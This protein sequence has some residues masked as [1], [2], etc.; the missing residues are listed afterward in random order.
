M[1]S[2]I[3]VA[4]FGIV[5]MAASAAPADAAAW[6]CRGSAH[7]CG[8]SVSH[9]AGKSRVSHKSSY[10]RH[11]YA[12]RRGVKHSRYASRNRVSRR[13][14]SSAPVRKH[15]VAH[16]AP[17]GR[18]AS[19]GMASYYWQGQMTASGAR[20]N[21]SALTAAHRSLPF[22]TRVRVTNRSNGRS[23]VVTI[24]DR[25]PFIGGRIIDLS[26]AAAQ[27]ISMTGQG[28]AAVSLEILGR[29]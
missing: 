19:S 26:R 29:S 12:P 13:H 7:V 17:A 11:A 27:A 14:Y 2:L 4:A 10:S 9:N 15:R 1:R 3:A 24:N 6:N 28:V 21:P 18:G 5:G 25:G 20:F 23:V 16:A 22:G 8:K